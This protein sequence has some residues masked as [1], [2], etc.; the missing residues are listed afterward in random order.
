MADGSETRSL[1]D[2]EIRETL[3]AQ[4]EPVRSCVVAGAANTDLSGTITVK[5]V[6]AGTG[7]VIKTKVSAFRYLFEHGLLE[8]IRRASGKIHFP[9]TGAS[10]LVTVPIDLTPHS[11]SGSA[12]RAGKVGTI[13]LR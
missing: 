11:L 7:R 10:T 13:E 1:S 8:C 9:A 4:S 6:V 2:G 5:W 12:A 3:D